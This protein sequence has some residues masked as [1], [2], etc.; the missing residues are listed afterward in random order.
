MKYSNR[1]LSVTRP[2]LAA[3]ATCSQRDKYMKRT[4]QLLFVVAA[5]GSLLIMGAG[6]VAAQPDSST[7]VN[8]NSTATVGQGQTVGQANINNQT[9]AIAGQPPNFNSG[10]ISTATTSSDGGGSAVAGQWSSQSNSN[11]QIGVAV[12]ENSAELTELADDGDDEN[13]DD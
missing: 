10:Q 5:V 6:S 7:T 2:S 13:G 9:G 12:S 4:T 3:W 1:C 8:Q 11:S